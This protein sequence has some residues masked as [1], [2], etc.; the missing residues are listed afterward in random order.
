VPLWEKSGTALRVFRTT[1]F[2]R[3]PAGIGPIERLPHWPESGLPAFEPGWV[4]LVGT[5]PGDPGLLTVHAVNA[6][7]QADIIVFDALVNPMILKLAPADCIVEYAGKRGGKPS[8]KQRD[9]T[10]RL[11]ELARQKKRVLRLKGG[12]PFIFGRGGEE[13]LALVRAGIPFRVVPGISAG[14]GALA[15]AG[16]PLTHRDTN[17]A[18]TFLTGHDAHGLVP[19]AV[20]WEALAKGSPVIVMYMALKHHEAIVSRLIAAG[21]SPDEAVAVIT[22]ATLPTQEVVE[23]TLAHLPSVVAQ[24]AIRPPAIIVVGAVVRFRAALDWMNMPIDR[25]SETTPQSHLRQRDPV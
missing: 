17:Q 23:T 21:R 22:D 16:I 2:V 19:S 24:R 20:D 13:A 3:Q 14:V 4:W 15:Y 11:I 9:I 18:V 7:N 10:Y 1:P 5:G 12:D 8:A 6:I 25:R